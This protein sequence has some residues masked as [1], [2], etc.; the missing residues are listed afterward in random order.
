MMGLVDG[1][2]GVVT[3]GGSGIGRATALLL[4]REGA[5]VGIADRDFGSATAVQREIEEFGGQALAIA[6]DVTRA[7][8]VAAMVAAVVA[9]FG[10]LDCAVNC[11]GIN[12]RSGPFPEM[13]AA[14]WQACL[15]VNLTGMAYCLQHE[16]AAI[17][18]GGDG[19]SIVNL[20]SAAALAPRRNTAAYSASKHAVV[21][22][23]RTAS[24]D[25]AHENIR[26]NALCPGLIETPMT[27]AAIGSG[28]YD[29]ATMSPMGRAGR[30]DEV[31]E[32][33]VWLCSGRSSYVTGVA[34]PVDGAHTAGRT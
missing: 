15:E 26:V 13:D 6:V 28:L 4:A 1:K 32:A 22:I 34:L 7:E 5:A 18:A 12:G 33:A 14:I 31:A 17:R 29:P 19:G 10:K 25:L 20:A 23:T 11:A 9:A 2:V 16:I 30:A 27:A 8:Q 3:G 21:G 24:L